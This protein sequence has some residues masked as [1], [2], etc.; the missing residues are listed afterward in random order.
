MS[1][2]YNPATEAGKNPDHT[3]YPTVND[4]YCAERSDASCIF[5][6]LSQQYHNS[7]IDNNLV[8]IDK[9]IVNQN[10]P[11]YSNLPVISDDWLNYSHSYPPVHL[12]PEAFEGWPRDHASAEYAP[13]YC[14]PDFHN[15]DY[16]RVDHTYRDYSCVPP[17]EEDRK[18]FL[19]KKRE[20]EKKHSRVKREKMHGHDEVDK[21]NKDQKGRAKGKGSK[22]DDD[23]MAYGF[24]GTNFPARL[25]DLLTF[26]EGI[27][28]IITWLPHGRAWI[29]LK[30]PDFVEKVAPSHFSISKFE[31]FT[32][33]VNG[34]GFKRITQGPDVNAYYHEMFLRGM[35]HLIQW[36]KRSTSLQG[37]RKIRADPRDEPNFYQISSLYPLPD[38]Y[39]IVC[40]EESPKNS[41]P[42]DACNSIQVRSSKDCDLSCNRGDTLM[43][44]D[45]RPDSKNGKTNQK[46]VNWKKKN[47]RV[48]TN[49][50]AVSN[51]NTPCIP[52]D[53]GIFRASPKSTNQVYTNEKILQNLNAKDDLK[54][55][56]I[57][58]ALEIWAREQSFSFTNEVEMDRE[59]A[60]IDS[61]TTKTS[62]PHVSSSRFKCVIN[63]PLT[64]TPLC[65]PRN[66]WDDETYMPLPYDYGDSDPPKATEASSQ[67]STCATG[68]YDDTTLG[69]PV[70]Y[71]PDQE[72]FLHSVDSHHPYIQSTDS[73]FHEFGYY[74][75]HFSES[76][77]PESGSE[78]DPASSTYMAYV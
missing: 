70:C 44:T 11:M 50:D 54:E 16:V 55:T 57:Q 1:L 41:L 47:L 40:D 56:S 33:Q 17:N 2:Y 23:E 49:V 52:E 69:P 27:S 15:Q 29:V 19:N 14:D 4:I 51:M 31:S 26:D 39:S 53:N 32:R 21:E 22:E 73:F 71:Y 43:K 45:E 13:M 38:Y 24:M 75:P 60:I 34:W 10:G 63:H 9:V 78:R 66:H 46:K 59:G 76:R 3:K 61:G 12:E 67:G 68:L 30:K 37:R 35:P 62:S 20:Y 42:D 5:H 64:M 58:D 74:G 6:D 72:I 28:D 25:H 65:G 48:V 36:M 8:P 77:G 18:R 7:G